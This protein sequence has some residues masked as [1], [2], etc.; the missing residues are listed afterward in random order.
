MK[1]GL[2]NSTLSQWVISATRSLGRCQDGEGQLKKR[3]VDEALLSLE[4]KNSRTGML[5][6]ETA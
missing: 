1:I 2:S 6:V 5:R 3:Q 4:Q